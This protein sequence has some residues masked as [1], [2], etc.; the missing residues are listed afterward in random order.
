VVGETDGRGDKGLSG[1][2]AC[3]HRPQPRSGRLSCRQQFDRIPWENL[4]IWWRR[5]RLTNVNDFRA[6]L[7]DSVW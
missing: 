5:G 1:P 7:V 4:A 2:L 6:I 3:R